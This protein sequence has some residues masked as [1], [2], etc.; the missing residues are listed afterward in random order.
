M[1][2]RFAP[3]WVAFHGET[4]AAEVWRALGQGRAVLVR[5]ADLE[6]R[7]ITGLVLPSASG[8]NRSTANLEGKPGRL[9]WL[10]A[11]ARLVPH[12]EG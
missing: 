1:C 2:E 9:E 10:R 7:T 4:S 11:F 3:N 12:G 6:G 5:P 8:A